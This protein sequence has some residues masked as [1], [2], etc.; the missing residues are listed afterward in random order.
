MEL[1]LCAFSFA[2]LLAA[3]PAG[4]LPLRCMLEACR[5]FSPRAAVALSSLAG[6]FGAGAMLVARGGLRA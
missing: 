4:A 2:V 5:R 3:Q 1:V 6:L